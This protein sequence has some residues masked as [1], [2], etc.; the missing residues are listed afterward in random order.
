MVGATSR[1]EGL[2][3]FAQLFGAK[4]PREAMR[5]ACS[6]LLQACGIEQPPVSL[7]RITSYLGIKTVLTDEPLS[8]EAELRSEN[9]S[10]VIVIKRKALKDDWRR[11]RFTIAH[12]CGHVLL[13]NSLRIGD[14]K[15]VASLD[16]NVD[17]HKELEL[18]CDWAAAEL[19][20]PKPMLRSAVRDHGITPDALDDLLKHFQVSRDA[21]IRNI[22]SV[23]PGTELFVW[24]KY[25]RTKYESYEYRLLR[26]PKYHPSPTHPWLPVGCTTTHVSPRIIQSAASSN[27]FV[28]EDKIEIILQ[29]RRWHGR[30]FVT[31]YP[32]KRDT[33]HA[34]GGSDSH[35]L[36][37]SSISN[38]REELKPDVIEEPN[39]IFLFAGDRRMITAEH[40]LGS[41]YAR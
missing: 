10:F 5:K 34:N 7:K 29:R 28:L 15:Y 18:L 30:G 2:Q 13:Y 20:M 22:V 27:S 32:N 14:A 6:D 31:F 17:A 21:L 4:N 24:K 38:G 16:A 40:F 26:G 25:A 23:L 39:V 9:G 37:I 1:S 41:K 11:A 3:Q 19:L 8:A 12:E 35:Q 36:E 33:I